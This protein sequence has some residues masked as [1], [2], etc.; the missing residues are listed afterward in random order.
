MGSLDQFDVVIRRRNGSIIAC[1]PD[2]RLYARAD[3]VHAAIDALD[4]KKREL[5]TEIPEIEDLAMLDR[6]PEPISRASRS[7]RIA[8]FA[9]KAAIVIALSAI[10]IIYASSFIAANVDRT[11][12]R[13]QA[14]VS[15][16]MKI[17]GREF[18]SKLE[19]GLAQ[20]AEP[21]NDLPEE[22]KQKLLSD[23]R[24][25]ATRWR[26]FLVEVGQL[27][28]EPPAAPPTSQKESQR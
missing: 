17:G 15:D 10:A 22:K 6:T 7:S 18:W 9:A 16:A 27:F 21:R 12:E 1:I 14:R 25:I 11:A 20:A 2:L 26:P 8:L 19:T 3:D 5:E 23:L 24:T 28:A 4:V 13:I